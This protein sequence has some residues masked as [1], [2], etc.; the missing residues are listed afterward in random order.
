MCARPHAEH[1]H[2]DYLIKSS[3]QAHV[4]EFSYSILMCFQNC[5]QKISRMVAI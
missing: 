2:I 1:F 4:F 3:Q 5:T